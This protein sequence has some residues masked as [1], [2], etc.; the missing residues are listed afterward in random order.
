MK[1]ILKQNIWSK[2]LV[3]YQLCDDYIYGQANE[4]DQQLNKRCINIAKVA[5]KSDPKQKNIQKSADVI[6]L[7]EKAE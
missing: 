7:M 1:K 5:E 2:E 4:Q 6:E 3:F